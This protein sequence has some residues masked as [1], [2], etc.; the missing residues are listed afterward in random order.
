M[1]SSG[2]SRGTPIIELCGMPPTSSSAPL[3]F[4]FVLQHLGHVSY[5]PEPQ[6]VG[7]IRSLPIRCATADRRAV[8]SVSERERFA[9]LILRAALPGP[10]EPLRGFLYWVAPSFLPY[11]SNLSNT[12]A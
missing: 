3:R 4:V 1:T 10:G 5:A 12:S 2:A 6:R 8:P 11:L 9:R 7:V